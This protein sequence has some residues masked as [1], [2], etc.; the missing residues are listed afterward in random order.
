MQVRNAGWAAV[1]LVGMLATGCGVLRERMYEWPVA[2]TDWVLAAYRVPTGPFARRL[3]VRLESKGRS[4]LLHSAKGDWYYVGC[5][6]VVASEDRR[7]VSYVLSVWAP[8]VYVGAYD[9]EQGRAL[10]EESVDRVALRK[11]IDRL[12]RGLPGF[13]RERG[14]D[15]LEWAK[16]VGDCQEAFHARFGT[17]GQ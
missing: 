5:A 12:Y 13:P 10:G 9:L 14:V 8:L 17:G 2:G 4:Q 15:L 3:E 1:V 11:E 16:D 6:A 7:V